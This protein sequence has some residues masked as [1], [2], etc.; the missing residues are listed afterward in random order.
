MT[1]EPT[2]QLSDEDVRRIATE[3]RRQNRDVLNAAV[4]RAI[5]SWCDRFD[6]RLMDEWRDIPVTEES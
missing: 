3:M 6:A 4:N 2:M 1:M 5:Q